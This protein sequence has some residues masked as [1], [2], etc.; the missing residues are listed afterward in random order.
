MRIGEIHSFDA[1]IAKH[2]RGRG[3]DIC[4]PTAASILAS[5]WNGFVLA[6][7]R[8]PLQD[9][10]DYYLA[11][12]QKGRPLTKQESAEAPRTS[13]VSGSAPA[14]PDS[15]IDS[16]RLHLQK[17]RELSAQGRWSEAGKELEAVESAVK[18]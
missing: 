10:N 15:K 4:K 14:V 6:G 18:K 7:E 12:I 8:A 11:N 17:Y 13:T 16:I 3:C 9:T 1:L 5:C 2:G